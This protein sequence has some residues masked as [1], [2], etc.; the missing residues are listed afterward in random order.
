MVRSIYRLSILAGSISAGLLVGCGG[1]GGGSSTPVATTQSLSI[2]VMDGLITG[3]LV[4]IDKNNSGTCE[5]SE[6]KATSNSSGVATL[7]VPLDD[8]GK[9]PVIAMVKDAVDADSGP[10]TVPYVLKLPADSIT[11]KS[12]TVIVSPLTTLVQR[13]A[14]SSGTSADVAETSLRAQ[15]GMDDSLFADYSKASSRAPGIVAA[16]LVKIAQ[17]MTTALKAA[18]GAAASTGGAI[19][20]ADISKEITNALL[21]KLT[22]I[23]HI[24]GQRVKECVD[25]MATSRCKDAS[26]N[27]A[28]YWANSTNENELLTVDKLVA[29]I[30]ASRAAAAATLV[31]SPA[32]PV[33]TG[34]LNWLW[35]RDATHWYTSTLVASAADN[36]PVNGLTKYRQEHGENTAGALTLWS[37]FGSQS[38]KDDVH[39]TGSAWSACTGAGVQSTQSVPDAKGNFSYS[40]CD[41]LFTGSERLVE[42]PIDGRTLASVV[43]QIKAYPYRNYGPYGDYY[44][45]WG[46][47]GDEASLL[48]DTGKAIFP[49]G[50]HL[51]YGAGVAQQSAPI[52]QPTDSN[53]VQV[54][55][56]DVVVGGDARTGATPSLACNLSNAAETNAMSLEQM[57]ERNPGKP[58]VIDPGT[59]VGKDGA[60]FSSGDRNERWGV[61]TVSMGSDMGDKPL[62]TSS[63]ATAYFTGNTKFRLSFA[64]SGSNAVTFY[65]CQ[66]RSINGSTRNCD[67]VGTGTYTITTLGDAR[68][69]TFSDQPGL[70]VH[71][72]SNR[73]FVERDGKVYHG[74]QVK[75]VGYK[76]IQL[77][78]TAGN[79]LLNK[80]IAIGATGMVPMVP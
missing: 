61:S 52:Y 58:C 16:S 45:Y 56:P 50:S 10:V 46:P 74:Y 54:D 22:S 1:G 71:H 21:G 33:A 62:G 41:A 18:E 12:V 15:L 73:V 44:P 19:T 57:V 26:D 34:A 6:T 4:C 43:M 20:A 51:Q 28:D 27:L 30:N 3:A 53:L 8:V 77:D 32:T 67:A 17:R 70:T 7:A 72:P 9:Y 49:A 69:M 39:W 38:Q 79:A 31:S 64:G 48:A 47:E 76:T 13:L 65:E 63:T 59:L 23:K 2:T 80:Y 29:A 60:A 5:D 42:V 14:E 55:A 66:Q 11:T 24:A 36:T 75:S 35:F 37:Y 68:V 25:G 40:T 78:L